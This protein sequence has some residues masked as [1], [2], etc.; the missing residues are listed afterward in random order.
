M[1]DLEQIS[2]E[3]SKFF[4]TVFLTLLAATILST[5]IGFSALNRNLNIAGDVEYE[6]YNNTLYGVLKK[7][8]E[9][10]IYA[11]EYTGD[12]HDSNTEEPSQKI[13]YWHG[14]YYDGLSIINKNNVL[15]ADHCWRMYRTTDTGGVKLIYAGIPKDG[16]C[17]YDR[18]SYI[19]YTKTTTKYVNTSTNYYYGTDYEYDSESRLFTLSGNVNNY[20]WNENPIGTFEGKYTCYS[21]EENGTCS[22]LYLVTP[23][24]KST[25]TESSA[26]VYVMG[27]TVH[28]YYAQFGRTQFEYNS[29]TLSSVGYMQGKAYP[30][31]TVAANVTENI[32]SS[33]TLFRS[34]NSATLYWYADDA[35]YNPD[36]RTWSLINPYKV[37]SSS[38]YPSLVG[39]YSLKCE[40]ETDTSSTIYYIVGSEGGALYY[41]AFGANINTKIILGEDYQSDGNGNY[42]LTNPIEIDMTEYYRNYSNYLHKFICDDLSDTCNKPRFMTYVGKDFYYYINIIPEILIAKNKNGTT[43][44]DTLL[45]KKYQLVKDYDELSDYRYTCNNTSATCSENNIRY[46]TKKDA[47]GYQYANHYYFGK[48]VTWDGEKYSLN[49]VI[50]YENINDLEALSSHHYF[51]LTKDSTEC[52][53][54]AFLIRIDSIYASSHQYIILK[55][56]VTTINEALNQMLKNNVNDSN[57]KFAIDS[58]YKKYLINYGSYLEDTVFCNNREIIEYGGWNPNGDLTKDLKFKTTEDMTSLD[59][60]GDYDRFS[61]SNSLAQLNYK[62]GIVTAPE[63]KIMG[64]FSEIGNEMQNTWTMTSYGFIYG[65]SN[66]LN[67]AIPLSATGSGSFPATYS[68]PQDPRSSAIYNENAVRPVIS[69]KPGTEF[70]SG[71]GTLNSPYVVDTNP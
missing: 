8:A 66:A 5:S 29:G 33:G 30:S 62:V 1:I 3:K 53:E 49:N 54:V 37:S 63:F 13:Y 24:N 31:S 43:L 14:G 59:C 25:S 6:E 57:I 40:N 56:G 19:G 36:T 34:F 23:I 12:H 48:S 61:V 22:T 38:Q 39:K 16:K 55:D 50:G 67:Y 60:S 65:S 35:E 27:L 68:N 46:R 51:C 32:A 58:W 10:T 44:T 11:T 28:S 45:V 26:S 47:W 64:E 2:N 71:N 69:L 70:I 20:K 4:T 7:A 42:Q 9:N 15:F 18:G 52:T 17:S 21:T 41:D